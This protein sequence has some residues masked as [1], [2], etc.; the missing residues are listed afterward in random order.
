MQI[1]IL[2]PQLS[3]SPAETGNP[4]LNLRFSSGNRGCSSPLNNHN[5][6]LTGSS[7]TKGSLAEVPPQTHRRLAVRK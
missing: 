3:T 2:D 6:C 7:A 5:E 1:R 4:A